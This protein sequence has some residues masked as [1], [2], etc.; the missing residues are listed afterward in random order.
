MTG[1]TVT[2]EF[3]VLIPFRRATRTLWATPGRIVP[4]IGRRGG[5]LDAAVG[6]GHADRGLDH[7]AGGVLRHRRLQADARRG[8]AR[9]REG[10]FLIVRQHQR[11]R[12]QGAGPR[13][14][15]RGA[16]QRLAPACAAQCPNTAHRHVPYGGMAAPQFGHPGGVGAG[17]EVACVRPGSRRRCRSATNPARSGRA[18]QGHHV[19]RA[20]V[21]ERICH[22]TRPSDALLCV[23]HVGAGRAPL[24]CA[25]SLDGHRRQH[26]SG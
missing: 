11:L 20:L 5:R 26:G 25:R 6:G 21:D 24:G 14:A 18:S 8:A 12:L 19:V 23:L 15:G 10:S 2:T 3:A 22:A 17:D 13:V 9:E 16:H 4:R 7:P 1:K